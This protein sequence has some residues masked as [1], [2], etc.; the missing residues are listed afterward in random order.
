MQAIDTR[1]TSM[2]R[3]ARDVLIFA[4]ICASYR[5]CIPSLIGKDKAKK[6]FFGN[7]NAMI[8]SIALENSLCRDDFPSCNDVKLFLKRVDS[9]KFPNLKAL[10]N[11]R[12]YDDLKNAIDITLPYLFL[13]L[14][15]HA[16][17]DPRD[18][19]TNLVKILSYNVERANENETVVPM[20]N[21]N[22]TSQN[23]LILREEDKVHPL[24]IPQKINR[25]K[26]TLK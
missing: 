8:E 9:S 17:M 24:H 11:M 20:G 22:I 14:K 19:K 25:A 23:P 10:K 7:Y 5:S 15:Q 16:M 18:R 3:R 1:V 2:L 26:V 13:P 4:T 21:S 12:L 6:S